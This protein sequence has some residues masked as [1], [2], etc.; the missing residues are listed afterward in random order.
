VT[1]RER[2]AELGIELPQ[3]AKPVASYV[4]VA[5]GGEVAFVA[6]QV[7]MEEG[8]PMATG[9]VGEDLTVDEARSLARRC[10]LQALAALE[11]ELGSLD[12]VRRVVKV[13]VWVACGEAFTEHPAVAN[14]AS[15]LLV[16]VFGEDGKHARAA[17]GAPSLPLGVPVEVEMVVQVA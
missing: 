12:R 10:A 2:L 15:D 1:V 9:R 14:G 17:V 8:K 11:E 3:A 6:G 5:G 4:P 13:T 7:P 16:D